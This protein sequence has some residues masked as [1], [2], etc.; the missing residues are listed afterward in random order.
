MIKWAHFGIVCKTWGPLHR[1]FNKGTRTREAPLGDSS[2]EDERA[3]NKSVGWM[4]RML[5]ILLSLNCHVTIENPYRSL[6]FYHPTLAK[7]IDKFELQFVYFD[8]CVYGLKSP[9]DVVE[10][11]IWRKPTYIVT[12]FESMQPVCKVCMRGHKHTH[13]QGSVRTGGRLVNRSKLAGCYPVP[14]CRRIVK[15]AAV[16][17]C[18]PPHA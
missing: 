7:I 11:E 5:D 13:I 17:L 18:Q 12:S 6:V 9:K 4:C 1:L 15:L 3:A 10:A 14:L 8:Q 16:T 2:R